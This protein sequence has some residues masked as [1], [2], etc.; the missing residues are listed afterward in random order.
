[1]L[2]YAP[3]LGVAKGNTNRRRR[4]SGTGAEKPKASAPPPARGAAMAPPALATRLRPSGLAHPPFLPPKPKAAAEK[5]KA[6]AAVRK[7]P[8]FR[9]RT[10]A[11]ARGGAGLA[12][13]RCFAPQRGQRLRRHCAPR[14]RCAVG[15][16]RAKG[17][18][19]PKCVTSVAFG[20]TP[21][22][23][24]VRLAKRACG[25]EALGRNAPAHSRGR[26]PSRGAK[27]RVSR[28]SAASEARAEVKNTQRR[29]RQPH[30]NNPI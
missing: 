3:C 20:N 25:A 27:R 10:A 9:A 14:Q 13:S 29:R 22:R 24:S 16:V 19:L 7:S 8:A 6:S 5:P 21:L 18:G 15:C 2:F 1:M 17:E 11:H 12:R 26:R 28:R 23:V 4:F 30:H